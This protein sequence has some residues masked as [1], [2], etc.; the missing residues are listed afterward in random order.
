MDLTILIPCL[1]EENSIGICIEKAKKY[2]ESRTISGE[3]L[4]SDNGS[5]DKSI[6]IAESLGARV[7]Q[8]DVKGYGSALLNGIA[9]AKG[10]YIIMGDADDSY[11]FSNLDL[12]VEKL[13]EGYDL[14]MGNR[15]WGGIEEGAMPWSHKY[16]G[17][18]VLSM[19][20]RILYRSKLRDWHCGLRGFN[21]ESIN[22]LNLHCTGMEFASEMVIKAE[23]NKLKTIE[24]PTKLYKDKRGRKPHLRSIPD[25]IRHLK[26][27][28]RYK[29]VDD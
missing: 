7:V 4:V 23:K 19:I 18:P 24:V 1:N 5:T 29:F 27:L 10:K 16:I 3:V 8:T 15:F 11:D 6:E 2:L 12:F 26:I 20:G 14:V 9:N 13:Q 21:R 28:L 17:N 22:A 25:G